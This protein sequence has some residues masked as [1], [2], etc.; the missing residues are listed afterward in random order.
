MVSTRHYRAPEVI[1]G[2]GW[3]YP[4]DMWSLGC[5]FAELITGEGGGGGRSR[6]GGLLTCG[7]WGASSR[8]SSQVRGDPAGLVVA[9]LI[10]RGRLR[11]TGKEGVT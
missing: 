7:A 3:S 10:H 6:G 4:A 9:E 5:I 1:L 11:A 2:L 8:S